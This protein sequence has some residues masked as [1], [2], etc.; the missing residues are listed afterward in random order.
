MSRP[1]PHSPKVLETMSRELKR[2]MQRLRIPSHPR[3]Y[4]ISYLLRAEHMTEV[5]GAYGGVYDSREWDT[6]NLYT[7]VRVGSYRF[8]NTIDGGLNSNFKE[9]NSYNWIAG[10]S[11]LHPEALA[12]SLWKLTQFK[13]EEALQSYYDR[14][15]ILVEQVNSVRVDSFSR[16]RPVR[17]LERLEGR[18]FPREDWEAIVRDVTRLFLEYPEVQ[19]PACE[20]RGQRLHRYFVNSEGS[21]FVTE[22]SYISFQLKGWTQDEEGVYH[23]AYRLIYF[24]DPQAMPRRDVLRRLVAEIAQEVRAIREAELMQDYVGPA[25]LSGEATG[26]FFHEAIGH[27]LEGERIISRSEGKTFAGK[28]GR[29]ILSP[30]VTLIDDPTLEQAGGTALFGHYQVDDEGVRPQRTLLVERGTLRNFLM[31]RAPIP[32]CRNSNGHARHECYMDPTA[33][34]GT[35]I[36]QASEKHTLKDLARM[37]LE[38]A[39]R[40][41]KQFALYIKRVEGGETQTSSYDFQA[42]KG[43]PVEVYKV[44]VETGRH[45]RIRNVDF[46]GTP[47]AALEK[48]VALGGKPEAMNAF[49]TAESGTIPVSSIAPSM[50]LSEIELQRTSAVGYRAPVLKPPWRKSRARRT[51]GKGARDG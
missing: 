40:Q 29:Q 33:R 48:I 42:F 11:D 36:V 12:Y 39:R 22:D 43:R 21:R 3:P 46:I 26:V 31:S 47:L 45:T 27:R 19:D 23:P 38:E 37:L 17:R 51:E 30:M 14:K 16:E 35:L 6:S 28:I 4:F 7:E 8:D 18:R 25:L 15:K 44:D 5:R 24:R 20:I 13:Y 41:G 2:S 10:P 1:T 9:L 50:L 32:G 49:C 34:M